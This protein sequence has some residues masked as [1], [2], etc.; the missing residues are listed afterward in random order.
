MHRRTNYPDNGQLA[1]ALQDTG[2]CAPPPDYKPGASSVL[3]TWSPQSAEK[4]CTECQKHASRHDG[5][6]RNWGRRKVGRECGARSRERFPLQWVLVFWSVCKRKQDGDGAGGTLLHM[7]RCCAGLKDNGRLG[8]LTAGTRSFLTSSTA[9]LI[10]ISALDCVS[11][12]VSRTWRSSF[13]CSQ[14]GFP[15]FCSSWKL[16][17]RGKNETW[18]MC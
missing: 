8:V 9:L 15:L 6:W 2:L 4:I 3:S 5:V 1:P 11:S 7:S 17:E 12:T 13:R 16:Q 10:L 14:F 18:Q